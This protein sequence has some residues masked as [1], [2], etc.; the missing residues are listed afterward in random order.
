MSLIDIAPSRIKWLQATCPFC[1]LNETVH[2]ISTANYSSSLE[3]DE[4]RWIRQQFVHLL[5]A[6]D[7]NIPPAAGR[8]VF[9]MVLYQGMSALLWQSAMCSRRNLPQ[10][11]WNRRRFSGGQSLKCRHA[12]R[13]KNAI[14]SGGGRT[15]EASSVT[16]E[17]RPVQSTPFDRLSCAPSCLIQSDLVLG[18]PVWSGLR[19]YCI[20]VYCIALHCIVLYCIETTHHSICAA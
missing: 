12:E 15:A 8:R 17:Q 16:A 3:R 13:R 6:L 4:H 11:S 10:S 9:P 18:D 19:L 5:D 14:L 1:Q 2:A 20:I 7:G